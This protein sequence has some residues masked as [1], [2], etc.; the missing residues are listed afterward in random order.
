[1]SRCGGGF[2]EMDFL[3]GVISNDSCDPKIISH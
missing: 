3:D 1:M 2:T